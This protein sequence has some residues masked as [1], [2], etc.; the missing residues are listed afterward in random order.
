M[1]PSILLE[2]LK[3]IYHEISS[4]SAKATWILL[5]QPCPQTFGQWVATLKNNMTALGLGTEAFSARTLHVQLGA[6]LAMPTG[7]ARSLAPLSAML[8]QVGHK[9]TMAVEIA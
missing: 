6:C 8:A 9:L 5:S 7:D 2:D 1:N 4:S 3:A